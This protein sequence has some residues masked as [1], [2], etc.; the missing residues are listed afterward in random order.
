MEERQGVTSEAEEPPDRCFVWKDPGERDRDTDDASA[1]SHFE[2]DGIDPQ[3]GPFAFNRAGQEG[4][5]PLVDLFSEP[6][7]LALG[8]LG[9]AHG[10]HEVIHGTGRDAVHISLLD[11]GG[12]RRLD[13]PAR[14]LSNPTLP[15]NSMTAAS[16]TA[17]HDHQEPIR[18]LEEALSLE[19]EAPAGLRRRKNFP[20]PLRGE[21]ACWS[22]M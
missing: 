1:L 11:H 12:Q 17:G 15:R 13:E 18:L 22:N 19:G 9:A 16:Y 3:T 21:E 20:L 4:I 6:A 7:D 10:V 2:V 8:N 14:W 5:H